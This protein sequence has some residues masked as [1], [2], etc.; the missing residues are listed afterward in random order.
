MSVALDRSEIEALLVFLANGTLVGEERARVEAAVTAD[1]ELQA[2]L[3][4][5]KQIRVKMQGEDAG[6]GP[7][8]F[9]LARLMRNIEGAAQ[10]QPPA[11]TNA[12]LQLWRIAAVV[13]LALLAAQTLWTWRGGDLVRLAGGQNPAITGAS[14][15]VAFVGTASEA[16]IRMLLL[17]LD[18]TIVS[19]PSALGLYVLV[20]RD[21]ASRD[22]AAERL[23]ALPDIVESVEAGE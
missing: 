16:A 10:V 11:N 4:V 13:A 20:A 12:P 19:G 23:A 1:P 14:L 18:L 3:D 22:V 21:E 5:L 7:G 17:D 6:K 9:G 15:T 2:Q 8:E